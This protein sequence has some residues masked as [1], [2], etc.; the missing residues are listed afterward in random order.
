MHRYRLTVMSPRPVSIS[1]KFTNGEGLPDGI[2]KPF[3]KFIP[4]FVIIFLRLL[5]RS[6][7]EKCRTI[8]KHK[9]QY[10]YRLGCSRCKYEW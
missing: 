4:Y 8:D 10:Q 5:R 1:P 9:Y 6:T 3:V 7:Y 2:R